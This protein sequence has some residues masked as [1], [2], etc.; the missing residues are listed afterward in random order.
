M[1]V[2]LFVWVLILGAICCFVFSEDDPED[3]GDGDDN[4]A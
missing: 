2:T 3:D 4:E 1:L